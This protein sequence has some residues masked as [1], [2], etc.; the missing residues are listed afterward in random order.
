ML[1][2]TIYQILLKD[3]LYNPELYKKAEILPKTRNITLDEAILLARKY[4]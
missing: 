2:T 4:E 1:L 3:E